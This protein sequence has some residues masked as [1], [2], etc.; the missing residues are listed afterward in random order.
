MWILPPIN[1]D[2]TEWTLKA[3]K[4]KH[5]SFMAPKLMGHTEIETTCTHWSA[6]EELC[7]Y[8]V[9][10]ACDWTL[11]ENCWHFRLRPCGMTRPVWYTTVS[12][13]ASPADCRRCTPQYRIRQAD[14]KRCKSMGVKKHPRKRNDA[15]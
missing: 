11:P 14:Y 1:N 7:S 8:S 3:D 6:D 15:K 9:V 4:L 13:W 10:S 5:N 12:L 2:Y